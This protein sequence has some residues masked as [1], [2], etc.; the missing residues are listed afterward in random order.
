MGQ[1][2][3]VTVLQG[4]QTAPHYSSSVK[5]TRLSVEDP[6]LI[7]GMIASC[8]RAGRA[9]LAEE[10]AWHPF[11]RTDCPGVVAGD[12]GCLRYPG[13]NQLADW[14]AEVLH[15]V[16]RGCSEELGLPTAD[17]V[18]QRLADRLVDGHLEG[19]DAPMPRPVHSAGDSIE[20]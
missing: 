13:S 10:H 5:A 11:A 16:Q 15:Q 17:Q 18:V 6:G 12:S 9:A 20:P 14:V 2:A 7:L 8:P 3:A 4:I 1:V 19:P